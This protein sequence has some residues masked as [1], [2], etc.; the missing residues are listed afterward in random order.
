MARR[1]ITATHFV[2][3]VIALI[4]LYL[5]FQIYVS[6]ALQAQLK[7]VEDGYYVGN[8]NGDV[9][10]IEFMNYTCHFCHEVNPALMAAVKEDGNVLLVPRPIAAQDPA[11]Q[12]GA[13]LAYA[14]GKQGQ[15]IAVH[16]AL[17]ERQSIYD[18]LTAKDFSARF[19]LDFETLK[20][21][22]DSN[23][24]FQSYARNGSLFQSIGAKGTPAFLINDTTLFEPSG[25][26]PGKDDFLKLFQEA[27]Q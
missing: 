24:V 1:R 19:D 5:V 6:M 2:Y 12:Y 25:A 15:F 23:D 26:M 9:K 4:A 21:D 17:F 10:I 14:A 22:M 3:A 11:S 20:E 27:R 7:V 18:E 16:N 13:K 8:K